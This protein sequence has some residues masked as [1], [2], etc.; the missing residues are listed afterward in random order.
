L[1]VAV[2]LALLPPRWPP[3]WAVAASA[4]VGSGGHFTQALPDIAADRRLGVR[5]LPQLIGER[6]SALAA[7]LLLL[8]AH[9]GIAIAAEPGAALQTPHVV[10]AAGLA[11]GIVACA[12]TGR[13][14][15]AFRLTLGS[16]ALAV[17]AFVASGS[18]L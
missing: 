6:A 10:L 4:L 9:L 3:A 1:P 15:A 12:L 7:G 8:A 11:A 18:R 13:P 16:A 2:A 14:R 17:A 5:G